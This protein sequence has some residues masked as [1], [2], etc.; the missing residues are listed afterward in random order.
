MLANLIKGYESRATMR[1]LWIKLRTLMQDSGEF[2][3]ACSDAVG[4]FSREE[5]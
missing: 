2:A 5:I 1:Y 4:V 3:A